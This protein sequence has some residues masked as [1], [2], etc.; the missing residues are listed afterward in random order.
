MT[1]L[2]IM[3]FMQE[4]DQ[5]RF[6]AVTL[7]PRPNNATPATR[8]VLGCILLCGEQRELVRAVA[9]AVEKE[10]GSGTVF[11]DEWF[12]YY[13]AGADGDLRLQSI[14]GEMCELVVVCVSNQYGGKPWTRRSTRPSARG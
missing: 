3:G 14:Y 6:H 4:Q 8:E 2:A 12:E 10:L 13:I 1:T 11:L 7:K 5:N 9:E